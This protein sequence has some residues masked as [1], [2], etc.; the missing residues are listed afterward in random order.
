MR[1]DNDNGVAMRDGKEK[2]EKD[3]A[4]SDRKP[5]VRGEDDEDAG[6]G[7]VLCACDGPVEGG[8]LR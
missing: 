6:R 2:G 4:I 7:G 8:W 3:P 5:G 1:R